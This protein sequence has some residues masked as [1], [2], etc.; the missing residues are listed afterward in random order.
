MIKSYKSKRLKAVANGDF[1]KVDA[2]HLSVIRLILSTLDT[3]TV[4]DDCDLPGK[5]LHPLKKYN[6]IRSSLDVSANWRITFEWN[7]NDV[8]DVDYEDTH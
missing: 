7:G 3:A 5:R 1:S 4:L 2:R 8:Y 6:P